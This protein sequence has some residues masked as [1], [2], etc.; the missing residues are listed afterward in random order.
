MTATM[1]PTRT[2]M[3]TMAEDPVPNQMM[4]TGPSAIFGRELSTTMYGS[5]TRR[6]PSLHHRSRA[7]LVPRT[8]AMAK[9]ASVSQSVVPIW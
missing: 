3:N 7:M 8:T 6:A 1:I 9:P 2:V 4:M 5:S